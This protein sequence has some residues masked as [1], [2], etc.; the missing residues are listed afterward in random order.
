LL[1]CRTI[2]RTYNILETKRTLKQIIILSKI[3][4]PS[5]HCSR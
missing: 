3:T 2:F 1:N 5:H 4:V